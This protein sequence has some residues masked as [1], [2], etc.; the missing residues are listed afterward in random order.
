M[1]LDRAIHAIH[2]RSIWLANEFRPPVAVYSLFRELLVRRVRHV[3][4]APR[5]EP[6]AGARALSGG[7]VGRTAFAAYRFSRPRGQQLIAVR[8]RL[9][10]DFARVISNLRTDDSFFLLLSLN[11]SHRVFP[12]DSLKRSSSNAR[13]MRKAHR[14]ARDEARAFVTTALL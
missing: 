2:R 10:S 6:A 13:S 12:R 5:E 4:K 7:K 8:G 14:E 9:E 1:L 3:G 11:S